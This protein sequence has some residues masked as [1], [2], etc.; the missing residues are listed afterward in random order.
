MS[1]IVSEYRPKALSATT[2]LTGSI[3]QG[4]L[5]QAAAMLDKLPAPSRCL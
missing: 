4:N 3:H 5:F 1:T 2:I